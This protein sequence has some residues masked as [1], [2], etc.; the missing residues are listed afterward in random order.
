[1]IV[2]K[3]VIC[4][5]VMYSY[6][7][8]FLR[9]KK[10]HYYNRFYLLFATALSVV[11]PFIKIPVFIQHQDRPG[12]LFYQSLDIIQVDQWEQEIV[13][14]TSNFFDTWFT[15]TNGIVTVYLTV[16]LSLCYI[17][18][19]S[20]CYIRK[21]RR[22]YPLKIIQDLNF[23][24]TDEEGT[25]FSF[26][27]SIFWNR[28]IE[29]T[30][31]EGQQIFRHELFHVTQKHS[32]DT[33]FV[34]L[35]RIVCWFNP[36]FHLIKKELKAIHEFLAD[37]FA[38]RKY[39]QYD[40]AE[41][42]ILQCMQTKNNRL[43]H[44]F[45]QNHIKRRIA[46]ITKNPNKKYSYW[47]RLLVLPLSIFL[48]FAFAIYAQHTNAVEEG[49]PNNVL[50][51]PLTVIIDA[52]HGGRDHGVKNEQGIMEK[53]LTLAIA[54]KIK[55]H[56]SAYGI[57]IIMTREDDVY[58][59]LQERTELADQEK[60]D[61]LI[62]IH[63]MANPNSTSANGFELYITGKNN[64]T[65]ES[66]KKLGTAIASRISS[67][68]KVSAL[69]QRNPKHVWMLD[70]VSCPAVLIEC[71]HLTN[72]NDLSFVL[73]TENQEKIARSILEGIVNYQ[74][75]S[76]ITSVIGSSTGK[77]SI[78][79]LQNESERNDLIR[80]LIKTL[81]YPKSAHAVNQQDSLFFSYRIDENGNASGTEF[82]ETL[83]SFKP[84][85]YYEIVIAALPSDFTSVTGEKI[86]F[87]ETNR[88]DVFISEVKRS[89]DV[90]GQNKKLPS[91]KVGK[92]LYKVSFKIQNVKDEND[93]S[94]SL[95]SKSH[96]SDTIPQEYSVTFTKVENPP[97]FPGGD[98]AWINYLIKNLRYPDEAIKKKVS[99]T[100]IVQFIIDEKGNITDIEAI[101]GPKEL[102]AESERIIKESGKW[103]PGR[104]NNRTV[105]A[106]YNQPIVFKTE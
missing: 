42:L 104:Q 12:H 28:N 3:M 60:A 37:E 91:K 54:K 41:L 103:I 74:Q 19:R 102:R 30:G 72:D 83:P 101:K 51:E 24:N 85:Q 62:S 88:K 17:F 2:V 71:G 48:F 52:G 4:S 67:F 53:D 105:K 36:F 100:V 80:H 34:E 35:I 10:F 97:S 15:L 26:F 45:F 90:F 95:T 68:Y 11:L 22:T 33:L 77:Q 23:Y 43:T 63:V 18:F 46:M 56:A 14:E 79:D 38:V 57:K 82:Y 9:N 66:S 69:K 65:V 31:K 40:Y 47:T 58:P 49:L 55:E 29:L 44:P 78:P 106:Y 20:L 27:K 39:N 32:V 1:M 25:P 84:D 81:R 5:G 50:V 76:G 98:T 86:K 73:K 87:T 21:L 16:A 89:L 7:L 6:Y 92:Y 93:L 70:K 59:E 96:N 99:G 64:K 13:N 8:L 75:S 61:L 94:F